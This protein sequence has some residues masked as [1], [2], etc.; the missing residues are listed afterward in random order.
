MAAKDPYDNKGY[1]KSI[2]V[3]LKGHRGWVEYNPAGICLQISGRPEIPLG[4]DIMKEIF[5][6]QPGE[7]K[8]LY[9]LLMGTPAEVALANRARSAEPAASSSAS[10]G[11][12]EIAAME[13]EI[14]AL[15]AAITA[16]QA[17]L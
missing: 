9:T 10:T 11:E 17:R 2:P 4:S 8:T 16:L 5:L 15:K 3:T 7:P 1:V 13:A 14:A 12:E 6:D